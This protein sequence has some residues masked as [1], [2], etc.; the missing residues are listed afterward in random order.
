[1]TRLAALTVELLRRV[2]SYS[3]GIRLSGH[4]IISS[5][6]SV[7]TVLMNCLACG[8]LRRISSLSAS[9]DSHGGNNL[10][11]TPAGNSGQFQ[12]TSSVK[13]S[14]SVA[15]LTHCTARTI[16]DLTLSTSVLQFQVQS[17]S[18][19]RQPRPCPRSHP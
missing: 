14:K 4:D 8:W 19:V 7:T 12:S 9:V 17:V 3:R 6:S 13:F 5:Q 15:P 2:S 1:M 11:G 18:V 10:T 16:S